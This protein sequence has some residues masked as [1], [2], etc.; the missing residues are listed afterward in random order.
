MKAVSLLKGIVLI[1]IILVLAVEIAPKAID[2]VKNYIDSEDINKQIEDEEAKKIRS[3]R[4][5]MLK[6][7][8]NYN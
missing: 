7:H 6:K 4:R 5:R 3:E 8:Y 2:F 1:V